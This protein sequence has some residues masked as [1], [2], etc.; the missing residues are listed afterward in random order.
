MAGSVRTPGPSQIW[1]ISSTSWSR[2]LPHAEAMAKFR[3]MVRVAIEPRRPVLAG[4][5]FVLGTGAALRLGIEATFLYVDPWGGSTVNPVQ[6][7]DQ[8]V[9]TST[10][11][12]VWGCTLLAC[13]ALLRR[14]NHAIALAIVGSAVALP[15]L[16]QRQTATSELS[17]RLGPQ[18]TWLEAANATLDDMGTPAGYEIRSE[19]ESS[20][21]SA[22]SPDRWRTRHI[23]E[24]T[25]GTSHPQ[26]IAAFASHLRIQPGPCHSWGSHHLQSFPLSNTQTLVVQQSEDSTRV[27]LQIM[28]P[29]RTETWTDHC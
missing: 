6:Q 21:E 5:C 19:S 22:E 7:L 26:A 28:Q 4:L 8:T 18:Q 24:P 1:G 23:L 12:L 17:D 11:W 29:E 2:H 14:G 13:G 27:E 25:D 10:A 15:M 3:R 20:L 9:A 16:A